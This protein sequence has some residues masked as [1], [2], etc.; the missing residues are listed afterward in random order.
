MIEHKL[1]KLPNRTPAEIMIVIFPELA[2]ALQPLP[3]I[4]ERP[5]TEDRLRLMSAR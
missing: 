1:P 2:A 5:I 4:T 3:A